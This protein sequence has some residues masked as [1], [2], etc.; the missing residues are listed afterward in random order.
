MQK[1][2]FYMKVQLDEGA[3]MPKH[4]HEMDA[5]YDLFSRETNVVPAGGSQTFDTGVH[6]AIDS[7]VAGILFSKSGLNVN[8][9]IT[10][11]GVIDAGYTGSVVVKLYNHGSEDYVVNQGDKISQIIFLP[12]LPYSFMKVK[13]LEQNTERGDNGFGSTGR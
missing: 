12:I 3:K 4:A 5:G 7:G 13:E 1:N 9:S 11:T 8:H 10:S 2:K 6:M